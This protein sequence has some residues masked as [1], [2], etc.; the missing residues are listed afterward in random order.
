[1][2]ADNG[3]VLG[4]LPTSGQTSS[5]QQPGLYWELG[6]KRQVQSRVGTFLS[7]IAD[8][9]YEAIRAEAVE[10]G[11]VL[12]HQAGPT[13]QALAG[14][15][16]I[17]C[18][19]SSESGTVHSRSKYLGGQLPRTYVLSTQDREIWHSQ[20]LTKPRERGRQVKGVTGTMNSNR[21]L[22][23]GPLEVRFLPRRLQFCR[24]GDM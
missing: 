3:Q 7:L 2:P 23:E 5:T 19:G 17:T 9:A 13:V 18:S 16:E 14:V 1:M 12:A 20:G 6:V 21:N 15:T 22:H 4:T 24:G 8:E 10:G 11:V